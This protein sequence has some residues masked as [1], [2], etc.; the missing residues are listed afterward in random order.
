MH[1]VICFVALALAIAEEELHFEH[2]DLHWGNILLSTVDKKKKINFRLNG[3]NYEIMTKGVEVA[4]IDFTLSRIECDS[5]VIFNDLS[6]DPD[7]F[8]A[9]GDYQFEI[10]KLMQKKNG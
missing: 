8:T 1:G 6:L 9:E 10:Y 5:V 4:I 7:L 3:K 2:R